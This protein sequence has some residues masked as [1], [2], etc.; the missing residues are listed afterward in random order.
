MDALYWHEQADK[1]RERASQSKD[2]PDARE[3][4]ELADA[5]EQVAAD[6]EDRALAG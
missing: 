3:L 5:C 6:L 1:F 2:Q 4:I